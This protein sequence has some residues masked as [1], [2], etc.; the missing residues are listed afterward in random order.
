MAASAASL[1]ADHDLEFINKLRQLYS[2]AKTNRRQKYDNWRRN[3]QLVCNKFGGGSVSTPRDSEIYPTLSAIAAWMTD[4]NTTVDVVAAADPYSDYYDFMSQVALDLATVMQ[5]SWTINNEKQQLKMVVWDAFTYGAGFFK[6]VWDES[7]AGGYG[8]A[9]AMRVDPWALYLDPNASNLDDCEFMVEVRRMSLAEIERRW[10]GKSSGVEAALSTMGGDL[11][12]TPTPDTGNARTPKANPGALEGAATRWDQSARSGSGNATTP[13]V[14]V[15]EFWIKEND[16][17]WASD[18]QEEDTG[19]TKAP[20]E[21]P[22]KKDDEDEKHVAVR[23]RVVCLAGN[24]ILMDEWADELYTSGGH[25]YDRFVFEENGEM[26]GVA[27]VDHLAH[28][29][30]A[31]NRLLGAVQQNAELIG[32]PIFLEAANS[33]LDRVNVINKPGQRLR[34]QGAGAMS[35]NAPHWLDPPEMPTYVQQLV[36]FWISRIE[37]TS[38]LSG[39]IK[40][41]ADPGRTPE[42]VVSTIQEAAFVRIRSALAN[43]EMTLASVGYKLADLIID[44]YTEPR[45]I[46]VVGPEGQNSA[47]A[48]SSRHFTVPTHKGASPLK[49]SLVIQAGASMPTS[50]QAR[51]AEADSAYALGI[52]DRQAWMEAHNFP[53]WRKVL[54]RVNAAIADGTFNPPGQRQRRQR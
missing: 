35:N 30:I 36:E 23:W 18:L 37:N 34:L 14:V 33:G 54:E 25:P 5:T 17:Y 47:L 15:Y 6:S 1:Q 3:Y 21:I 40:G 42:G 44:N 16:E 49:Y 12:D 22:P 53:N 2:L 31:L 27:L 32:N 10:P 13:A 4:Q 8:D 43:L 45:V 7:L 26:Y 38:G 19:L 50:R 24:Q 51:V 9:K 39:A 52:I 28:P 29:Q 46:A 11:D 41:G 48:L 20:S